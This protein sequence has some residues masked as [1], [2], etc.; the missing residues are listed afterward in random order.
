MSARDERLA[1]AL[2]DPTSPLPEGLF[3]RPGRF[4]IHRNTVT[5]GLIDALRSGFPVITRLLGDD[6]MNGLA[7][8][9]LRACPPVSPLMML[10]GEGFPEFLEQQPQLADLGYLGD[11]ARL[12]LALR[13]A[14]HAA[15]ATPL[16]AEQ[17]AALPPERL[18]EV[19][20]DLAPALQLL[21]SPWPILDI[22]RF[23]TE[24]DAPAPA[25]VAQDVL[26]IR[27][28]YDPLPQLLPPGGAGFVAALLQGAPLGAAE[29]HARA[30]VENFDLTALF[31]LLLQGGV[32]IGA[33]LP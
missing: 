28:T 16:P 19:R 30:E 24:A 15:D 21:R 23:N 4:A 33:E 11:V 3:D 2:L 25:A 26:I 7:R 22:W 20:L 1:R 6:N 13:R 5:V 14:Y 10:Y 9:F 12:E 32:I 18:A 8:R 27:P 31:T 17:L 29:E